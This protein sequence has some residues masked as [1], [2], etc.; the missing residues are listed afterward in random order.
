[1]K[2][3]PL[4]RLRQTLVKLLVLGLGAF[5]VL[6]SHVV[7]AAPLKVSM[8]DVDHGDCILIQTPSGKNIMIDA[9]QYFATNRVDAFLKSKGITKIN[10]FILTHKHGDHFEGGY[11]IFKNYHVDDYY[12][13]KNPY[14]SGV[15]T[16]VTTHQLYSSSQ[17]NTILDWGDG[18][19]AK[20]LNFYNTTLNGTDDYNDNSI[21]LKVTYLNSSFLFT[22]DL[23]GGVE[24]VILGRSD[25]KDIRADVLKLGHHGGCT[26]T[27]SRFIQAVNPKIALA[28][29]GGGSYLTPFIIEK[30]H[31]VGADLYRTD[32]DGNIELQT[33][34]TTYTV[35]TPKQN[36][37]GFDPFK[38]THE[39]TA[40]DDI[41]VTGTIERY[42]WSD[43]DTPLTLEPW[44]QGN[45]EGVYEH[46]NGS[47]TLRA[48]RINYKNGV[49]DGPGYIYGDNGSIWAES[50][51]TNG[52]LIETWIYHS[53][54]KLW[55]EIL[56]D[57]NGEKASVKEFTT[58]GVMTLH[59]GITMSPTYAAP[60]ITAP[61]ANQTTFPGDKAVFSVKA[62]GMPYPTFQWYKN[63]V[64]ISG[65]TSSSYSVSV[66]STTANA[67]YSVIAKN[68][69]GSIKA[70]ATLTVDKTTP[71]VAP[72]ITK[73][74]A[75]VSAYLGEQVN[76]SLGVTG[77]PAPHFRWQKIIGTS[78]NNVLGEDTATHSFT[79]WPEFNGVKYRAIIS[80]PAGVVTSAVAQ[81]T[82]K[83]QVGVAIT[84]QPVGQT[85][86]AG[87]TATF[88]V[89]ATGHP[90]P[91]YCWQRKIN[92]I[93]TTIPGAVNS[94]YSLL[95]KAS[96]NGAYFRVLISHLVDDDLQGWLYSS[97]ALLKVNSVV[98][99]STPPTIT[100]PLTDQTVQVGQ[101]ATF[102]VAAT[103]TTAL[104]Y[105]WYRNGT[106]I[107]GASGTSYTI[108][109][110]ALTDDGAIYKVVVR[111]ANNLAAS[112][113]A[114]LHVNPAPTAPTITS[115]PVSQTINFGQPVTF[116]VQATGTPT[117][118]YQWLK[119]GTAITGATN[120]TYTISS[121][122]SS[123]AGSYTVTVSNAYGSVTSG[124][125]TL[126]VVTA[127]VTSYTLVNA[128]TDLDIATLKSGDQLN[129]ATLPSRNLN[130]RANFSGPAASVKFSLTGALTYSS[131][132]SV[133]PFALFGDTNGD[134]ASQPL[135]A[136]SYTLKSTPYSQTG[137]AGV[138]GT[139]LTISFTMIDQ[140]PPVVQAATYDLK[141][142][143]T[144]SATV[145]ASNSPQSYA[146]T[147][148]ALPTGLSLDSTTGVISGIPTTL[149]SS[150]V[151][152][153]ATNIGGTGSAQLT[154]N[155]NSN[156]VLFVAQSPANAADLQV[157]SVLE[158]LGCVVTMVDDSASQTS[159]ATGKDLVVISSTV[160]SGY[161]NTKF[162][163]VTAPVI[164]WES[165]ILDD[166]KMTGA[167]KYTD[168]YWVADQTQVVIDPNFG[169]WAGGVSGTQPIYNV[170]G[171][172][173]W[174]K[175]AASANKIATLVSDPTKC[176]VFSYD[177]GSVLVDGS[178]AS[179][180]R[181][182]IPFG[183][184]EPTTL[185]S[186]GSS[187][188][189]SAIKWSLK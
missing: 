5:F 147:A 111:D 154:F 41:A 68:V 4:C 133:A 59:E 48:A 36:N 53:P 161:V 117:L 123:N 135:T 64:A 52:K 33:D 112:S 102:T 129:L 40:T 127:K 184:V 166:M 156:N 30:V 45:L 20:V 75:S 164:T 188:L 163:S 178:L 153:S 82:T 27:T 14:S 98:V 93:W 79:V 116:S 136:G 11:M 61:P 152:I 138:A 151:T 113:Q 69:A 139:A 65:A 44:V 187:I 95:T 55:K 124:A 49:R 148:G 92:G 103:G 51:A 94:S 169:S 144:S 157:K 8:I 180:R 104:T 150:V 181:T 37:P 13:T 56:Y 167:V 60:T 66:S 183:D 114:T 70:S 165:H 19:K 141:Q 71:M 149:G 177:T 78:T 89:V 15:L 43:N 90:A 108:A 47:S 143:K 109:N 1:M 122:A 31:M 81:I 87:Q 85:V 110:P 24:D 162:L 186:V 189:D 142:W 23:E 170:P 107:S 176:V 100:Q 185:T 105:Q 54:G 16:G 28:N 140:A 134:Y 12:Y 158:G 17:L 26:A 126:T 173:G 115:G 137:G 35:N 131:T 175:P 34:G 86:N 182:F 84:T 72:K 9:G 2:S 99:A 130:I 145:N 46:G 10:T 76:L 132:D 91:T 160:T 80:N 50:Y 18:V 121:V 57:A 3:I 179:G 106:L 22:G 159:D 128:D 29:T 118:A 32:T 88:S 101:P 42:W 171:V 62:A 67:T 119:N 125:A 146:V 63:D 7:S 25:P 96:D 83:T 168:Y 21:V 155:V 172:L 74:I 73:N 174:G 39:V 120:S 97:S 38:P 6:I 77:T 58:N